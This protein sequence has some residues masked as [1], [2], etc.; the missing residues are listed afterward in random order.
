MNLGT[1]PARKSAHLNLGGEKVLERRGI[2]P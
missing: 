2:A 1:F